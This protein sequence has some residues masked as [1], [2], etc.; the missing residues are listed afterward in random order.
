MVLVDIPAQLYCHRTQ[1]VAIYPVLHRVVLIILAVANGENGFPEGFQVGGLLLAHHL[2]CLGAIACAAKLRH[3]FDADGD[4]DGLFRIAADIEVFL[5]VENA[6]GVVPVA[7]TLPIELLFAIVA[8]HE[9]SIAEISTHLHPALGIGHRPETVCAHMHLRYGFGVIAFGERTT[10]QQRVAQNGLQFTGTSL[11]EEVLPLQ[12]DVALL[13][14]SLM[15]G[16]YGGNGIHGARQLPV[17]GQLVFYVD[18]SPHVGCIRTCRQNVMAVGDQLVGRIVAR[19]DGSF[20]SQVVGHCGLCPC[21][22]ER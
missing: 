9:F 2:A 14:V 19:T 22:A 18:G 12:V 16:M 21:G 17:F 8:V 10:R 20:R 3:M 15:V 4:E 13:Q 6:C 11:Y 7:A 5:V 1:M